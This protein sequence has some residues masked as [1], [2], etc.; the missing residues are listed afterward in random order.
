MLFLEKCPWKNPMRE[1]QCSYSEDLLLCSISLSTTRCLTGS[2]NR[3]NTWH[4]YLSIRKQ[5][6]RKPIPRNP[7]GQLWSS[8]LALLAS[9]STSCCTASTLWSSMSTFWGIAQPLGPSTSLLQPLLGWCSPS[10]PLRCL[11]WALRGLNWMLPLTL[12]FCA[13]LLALSLSLCPIL[14]TPRCWSLIQICL[15][16][17]L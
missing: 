15:E 11:C 14:T 10:S 1:N 2:L 6:F 5:V 8:A 17:L 9:A 7:Q 4:Q 3:E 13:G 16:T 12:C